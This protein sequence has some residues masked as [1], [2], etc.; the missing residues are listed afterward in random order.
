LGNGVGVTAKSC[1]LKM[2]LKPVPLNVPV[3]L[4]MAPRSGS[5]AGPST[6]R[7]RRP[8]DG[9]CPH[10]KPR[11]RSRTGSVRTVSVMARSTSSPCC[12]TPAGRRRGVSPASPRRPVFAGVGGT[13]VPVDSRHSPV[14]DPGFAERVQPTDDGSL[15]SGPKFPCPFGSGCCMSVV[16]MSP[17]ASMV[18]MALKRSVEFPV[19]HAF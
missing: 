14:R 8:T 1:G 15:K 18:P 10:R 16:A 9:T 19:S 11:V 7:P 5:G 3:K 12:P 13:K 6:V 17:M 4:A 2:E